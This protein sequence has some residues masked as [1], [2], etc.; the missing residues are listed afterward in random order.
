[1]NFQLARRE[2]AET[3]AELDLLTFGEDSL[4]PSTMRQEIRLGWCML[5]QIDGDLA[6]YALV[7][8]GP[9]HDLLRLGVHPDYRRRGIA[10]NL[11]TQA[12]KTYP[13]A[14]MLFVRKTN[15]PALLLYKKTGFRIAGVKKDSW[16][17]I[18]LHLR[19]G[20]VGPAG[21]HVHRLA[22]GH[23]LLDGGAVAALATDLAKASL[24]SLERHSPLRVPGSTD[25]LHD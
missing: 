19:G 25:D 8:P 15:E 9:L 2:D 3:V 6:G 10:G 1:M 14:M 17:M 13:E 23:R 16:L 22:V 7:R 5:T 21:A 11:L 4:G 12:V 24:P 20:V 18:R